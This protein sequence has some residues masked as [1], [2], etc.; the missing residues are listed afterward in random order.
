MYV[1]REE[2]VMKHT[3]LLALVLLGSLLVTETV[4]AVDCPGTQ[5]AQC[6]SEIDDSSGI[7]F[8]IDSTSCL[9]TT[10]G[11]EAAFVWVL[12][13]PADVTVTVTPSSAT[14]EWD[15]VLYILPV[16][17]GDCDPDNCIVGADD[18]YYNEPETVTVS[19]TPATYYIVVDGHLTFDNGDFHL[20][21]ECVYTSVCDADLTVDCGDA[22]TADTATGRTNHDYYCGE[23]QPE[24]A[25]PEQVFRIV[26]AQAG[27]VDFQT[28]T[29]GGQELDAFVIGDIGTGDICDPSI[30]RDRSQSSGGDERLAFFAE[31]GEAYYL[32]VDGPAGQAGAFDYSVA[33]RS[34]ACSFDELL[35]CGDSVSGDSSLGVSSV[36]AY[37]GVDHHMLG[38]DYVYSFAVPFD[39]QVVLSLSIDEVAGVAP[40]LALLVLENA[41]IPGNLLTHSDL[42]QDALAN[43]PEEVG[44][45]ATAGTEYFV[46][47]DARAE[48]TVGTYTLQAQCT[49]DCG[50]GLT[51]CDY[52]CVDLDTD[53]EH[54]GSCGN[55]CSY[56]NAQALCQ[57]GGCSLGPC[58]ADW[59]DCN[60]EES[61]GCETLLGTV[62]D[63]SDCDDA[64][65]FD[66]AMAS[67][68]AGVCVMG[69]CED[70]FGD[71]NTDPQDGCETA[72]NVP[73]TCGACDHSC[74]AGE[75]C[76]QGEC[77]L[78]CP[79]GL[80][81]CSGACI[82]PQSDPY[83]CGGCDQACQLPNASSS[84]QA[85]ACV[86]DQCDSGYFD[87][88]VDDLDG[89]EAQLGTLEN[90]AACGDACEYA[91]A[92]GACQAG[93]C[94]MGECD[95]GWGN[96]N[97]LYADGCE[98]DLR[99]DDANCGKCET[100]CPPN[101]RCEAG[102]C[103]EYCPDA[104]QD[105][106][107]D[108]ACGGDDCDDDDAGIYP[109]ATE[110]CGDGI[111]Q[112]CSG[113]DL[114]CPHC[115]DAD[116]DGHPD[117][118]CGGDDCD[119]TNGFIYP[120]AT[121]FCDDGV[122]QDCDGS[123]LA[124]VCQDADN[125]GHT[126]ANCG[127][128]DCDDGNGSIYPQAPEE[129]EDGIDQDCDG[130]DESCSGCGCAHSG[131]GRRAT[132]LLLILVP[133][134]SYTL[135]R[136]RRNNRW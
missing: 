98:S 57:G 92:P 63:C 71:C 32:V 35:A 102:Q 62:D 15:P 104:D 112:D 77:V 105:G 33:C 72:L 44:F 130:M 28:V 126:S 23:L 129:C 109:G 58:N 4:R 60:Q 43:P 17:G 68:Q 122:D 131:A 66:H 116:G 86:V 52:I 134:L 61:D 24:Y 8:N 127:G 124:C 65:Q 31:A 70:G 119:D 16:G 74:P 123:D 10:T 121:E 38:A 45:E 46:V 120:G 53:L 90:C 21:V 94:I 82:D 3:L 108:Q 69:E 26:P 95:V 30:C 135:R 34:E 12:D 99:S 7:W 47:V 50:L 79:D 37:R 75:A 54:C 19:L 136:N 133:C 6:G 128:D 115:D 41:C 11:S 103:Q 56:P 64:C 1:Y 27:I 39:C 13:R 51:Q 36:T 96:C 118:A 101:Q 113:E 100:V 83:H 91:H 81:N 2:K 85:G 20:S 42:L 78:Q 106:H 93:V 84:C 110:I 40:D 49:L 125:D 5:P 114:E 80:M 88:N 48:Q 76:H 18:T 59:E 55:Q 9:S 67:C 25:A 87:C 132:M 111:D 107:E 14:G 73:E 89:C 117:Q 29:A 22:G 97:G